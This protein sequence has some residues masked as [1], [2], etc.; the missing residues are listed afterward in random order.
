[1]S[2][3][4]P[5]VHLVGGD[6]WGEAGLFLAANWILE[7]DPAKADFLCWTG[8][9]DIDPAFYGQKRHRTTMVNPRRDLFERP[10]F[11]EF[12]D[13]MK[14]GICRGGQ[15]LNALSG[16]SMY[17]HVDNHHREHLSY[18]IESGNFYQFSSVHHQM[19]IPGEK[20]KVLAIAEGISTFRETATHAEHG[21]HADVEAIFYEDT[22]SF[23]FQPH[24]EWGPPDCT[25]YFFRKIDQLY[26]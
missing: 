19:M 17:Q 21:N 22:K 5:K 10:Y 18:D 9:A 8:G 16:G 6:Q 2:G 15:L 1:M 25:E 23:C 14:L 13:K 26:A 4:G 7:G 24:P 11:D 12:P 3:N 20:G